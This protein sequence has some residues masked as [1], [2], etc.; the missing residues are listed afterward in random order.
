MSGT[1]ARGG[2]GGALRAVYELARRAA[3]A[4]HSVMLG[5]ERPPAGHPAAAARRPADATAPRGADDPGAS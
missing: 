4:R 5:P 3:V 1:G 2:P